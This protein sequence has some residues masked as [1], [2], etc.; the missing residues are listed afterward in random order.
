MRIFYRFLTKHL[1]RRGRWCWLHRWRLVG[2]SRSEQR[3]PKERGRSEERACPSVSRQPLRRQP[4]P[5]AV[6]RCA[7]SRCPQPS[8][9]AVSR[10]PQPSAVSRCR[11][12][13]PSA[14]AVA[15]SVRRLLGG[16]WQAVAAGGGA[17]AAGRQGAGSGGFGL[18]RGG[19]GFGG[20]AVAAGVP[21][22]R[23]LGVLCG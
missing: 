16:R 19:W 10:C 9:A 4:L 2:S 13:Q 15:Q 5:S 23:R 7:V 12:P 11:C 21:K 1:P 14:V 8:A 18:R 3:A 6:S 20:Q 22:R 17:F